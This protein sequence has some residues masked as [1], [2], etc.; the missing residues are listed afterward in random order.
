MLD[1]IS[2]FRNFIYLLVCYFLLIP[3]LKV[4]YHLFSVISLFF[5]FCILIN[6]NNFILFPIY[7]FVITYRSTSIVSTFPT[8]HSIL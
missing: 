8:F 4:Q 6:F 1:L 5:C 3:N 2:T 7:F